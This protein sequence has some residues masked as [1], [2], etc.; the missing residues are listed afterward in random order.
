MK[1]ED[2]LFVKKLLDKGTMFHD[3]T[4]FKLVVAYAIEAHD[5]LTSAREFIAPTVTFGTDEEKKTAVLAKIE[6]VLK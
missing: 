2:L 3:D 4:T 5:A 6:E 1:R